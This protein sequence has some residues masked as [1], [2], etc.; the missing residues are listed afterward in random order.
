MKCFMTF[1]DDDLG[2]LRDEI[3][4]LLAAA[5]QSDIDH[6]KVAAGVAS[7]HEAELDQLLAAAE[8][9]AE[10]RATEMDRLRRALES[11]DLIGQAKGVL[12][13][14]MRCSSD[15]AF[16]VLVE[17]SEREDRKLVEIAGEVVKRALTRARPRRT[18]N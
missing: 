10:D 14:A 11:R 18:I 16:A 12:I 9:S 15:D 6:T 8:Q 4:R 17:Q 3:S 5:L 2:S 13:V 1:E 7:A